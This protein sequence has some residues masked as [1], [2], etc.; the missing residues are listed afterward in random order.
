MENNTQTQIIRQ[1]SLKFVIEY[2]NLVKVPLGMQETVGI[3]EI[4]SQY[5]IEGRTPQ[6]IEKL[7]RFDNY[8]NESVTD[9][10][11]ERLKV[12]LSNG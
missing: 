3:A 7:K 5:V 6:V 9:D 11:V 12:E 8:V 4:I 2:L 10:I 1:S